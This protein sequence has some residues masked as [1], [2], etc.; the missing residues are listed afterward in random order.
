M[1]ESR[2]A[3]NGEFVT[4]TIVGETI[5]VPVRGSVADLDAIYNLN[6]VGSRIWELLDGS[7]TVDE[8]T[9]TIG[10]EFDVSCQEA[11]RDV[12]EFLDALQT[13]RIIR[14]NGQP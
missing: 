13:L 11:C 9:R 5:I 14:L 3:K 12:Q 1:T 10:R 2:F 6:E 7:T 8:I 4:R